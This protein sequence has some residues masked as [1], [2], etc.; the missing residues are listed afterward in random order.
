MRNSLQLSKNIIANYTSQIY[1]ALIGIAMIPH[2]IQLM[3]IEAYGLVAFFTL[4]QTWFNLLDVGLTPAITREAARYHSGKIS[5]TEFRRLFRALNIVFF[6]ISTLGCVIFLFSSEYIVTSWLNIERIQPA[7]A[8]I[9]IQIMILCV[10]TRWIGGLYRGLISG[11]ERMLWLSGYTLVITTAR[12]VGV[13]VSMHQFGATP[14][15]FFV[16]QL[17]VASIELLGLIVMAYR[18]MPNKGVAPG[19]IGWSLRPVLTM[20]KFS[21][22]IAFTSTAWI[23]TA[24][25]DKLILSGM[26]PISEYAYFMTAIMVASGITLTYVPL[27]NALLPRLA[28][29]HAENKENEM[30]VIYRQSTKWVTAITG[31]ATITCLFCADSILFAWSGDR[32]LTEKATTI[33]KLYA[34]GNG[35]LAL[36]A[37]PYYLQY[38]NGDMRY[39]LKGSI[40]T[41]LLLVPS[42]MI[43]TKYY[44][45]VGA[46]I[47]WLV[48]NGLIFLFWVAYVHHKLLPGLHINWLVYDVIC[49]ATPSVASALLLCMIPINT[50]TR[51]LAFIHTLIFSVTTLSCSLLTIR[52]LRSKVI[53]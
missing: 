38:A 26:L 7:D 2:Y 13:L 33:L 5:G 14:Y 40:I 24:Q 45:G 43:A 44:G 48:T 1:I 53:D 42:I 30:V 52:S 36:S 16:H 8:L 49:V 31:S 46:G 4:L 10:A 25:L 12:F 35:L 51:F 37:F 34:A 41:G 6:C 27:S 29:L 19:E 47:A 21:L 11:A 28:R 17:V 9:A 32:D 22:T 50:D 39:H 3:G 20:L 15:V 23:I 18:I